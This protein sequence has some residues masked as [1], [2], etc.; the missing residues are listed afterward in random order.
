MASERDLELLD[1]Y[2]SNRLNAE[3]RSAFEGR[4]EADPE[5]KGEFQLQNKIAESIRMARK[6]ELKAMLGAI[7]TASIPQ[8]GEGHLSL[9]AKIGAWV[10]AT[11]I[12]GTG[13][14]FYL[15]SNE[16][17]DQAD[18]K[19]VIQQPDTAAVQEQP[20]DTQIAET[21]ETTSPTAEV[22]KATQE[23]SVAEPRK[24]DIIKPKKQ[25]DSG[26]VQTAK[27][28]T[29]QAYD[30]SASEDA[31]DE[32]INQSEA[33]P[34]GKPTT[35]DMP[36]AYDN[37]NKKYKFHYQ[38]KDGKLTLYGPFEKTPY[39]LMAFYSDTKV[40]RFLYHESSYYLLSDENDKIKALSPINDPKLIGKLN[41]SRQ[42]EN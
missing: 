37:T 35:V 36:V 20:A 26:K 9:P 40:T 29:I 15:T 18:H 10:A 23:S 21:S 34:I 12:V 30:P 27:K 39:E 32:T 19:E 25:A 16:T 4:L 2:I 6:A 5:L 14:Y 38:I 42:K 11:A 1:D 24:K 22:P 41:Q 31:G 3:E 13:I 7:P 8:G 28:P 33:G 17:T